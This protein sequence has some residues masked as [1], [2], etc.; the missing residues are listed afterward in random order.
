MT[1]PLTSAFKAFSG[2]VFTKWFAKFLDNGVSCFPVERLLW[3]NTNRSGGVIPFLPFSSSEKLTYFDKCCLTFGHLNVLTSGRG[4]K[5]RDCKDAPNPPFTEN[6]PTAFFPP[7][8]S[9]NPLFLMIM[10]ENDLLEGRKSL[11]RQRNEKMA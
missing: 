10:R 3:P 1:K 11:T 2:K 9:S 4:W 8:R 5:K 6:M 7:S